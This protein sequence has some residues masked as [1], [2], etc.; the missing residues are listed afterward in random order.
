MKFVHV[1]DLHVMGRTP[2]YRK[3]DF[4]QTIL[5]KI[6]WVQ[7]YAYNVGASGILCTGDLFDRADTAYSILN[8]LI[9]VMKKSK[10]PWVSVIGNHDEYGYNPHTILRTPM[11][12]LMRQGLVRHVGFDYNSYDCFA[13]DTDLVIVTGC[14]STIQTDNREDKEF[15]YG[16]YAGEDIIGPIDEKDKH[17]KVTTVHLSH[18]FLANKNWGDKIHHTQI[19]EI[20]NKVKADIV[21]AGHEHS[22]FG[23]VRTPN[24]KLFINGGALGRIT[25]GV[26][27]I[28]R[29][30]LI[31]EITIE[32][33]VY[34]A[35]LVPVEIAKDVDEIMDIELAR[36]EKERMEI[37][38]NFTATTNE[39]QV[40]DADDMNV[41]EYMD[42]IK[43]ELFC[44]TD[45]PAT[46]ITN[47]VNRAKEAI[48]K[49]HENIGGAL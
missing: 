22:G 9:P 24:G 35:K 38:N 34:D 28:N 47:I 36:K 45:L 33:G 12:T 6:E 8:D 37:L 29:E 48:Q 26:G 39:I 5:A 31:S 25:A 2:K 43:N 17:K 13:D 3:D 4:L 16:I 14:D 11:G 27:D 23:I 10:V 42:V 18:G 7:D 15:D 41:F 21:L 19:N 1:T 20:C 46:T 49:A 44:N 30:V 32:N 40:D